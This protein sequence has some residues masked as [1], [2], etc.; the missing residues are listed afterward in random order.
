MVYCASIFIYFTR[1]H[2]PAFLVIWTVQHASF[3]FTKVVPTFLEKFKEK[4]PQVVQA[5]QEA[6]DAVFLTV[7]VSDSLL[8]LLQIYIGLE[9]HKKN[10]I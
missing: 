3:V 2:V 10:M 1:I 5:L 6:I 9:I 7:S 8:L 4:K